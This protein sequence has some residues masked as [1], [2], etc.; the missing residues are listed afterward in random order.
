MC[1]VL[2]RAYPV[3]TFTPKISAMRGEGRSHE[4]NVATEK[5]ARKPKS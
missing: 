1:R 3:V 4:I 5:K 2:T